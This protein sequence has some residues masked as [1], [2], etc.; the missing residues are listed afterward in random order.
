MLGTRGRRIVATAAVLEAGIAGWVAGQGAV[1]LLAA[2]GLVTL[3]DTVWGVARR[4]SLADLAG[5]EVAMT[6]GI[7]VAFRDDPSLGW[8]LALA[9]V[10][11]LVRPDRRPA[12]QATG[13][14]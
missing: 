1:W 8:L 6:L 12:V 2:I 9:C 5:A 14:A 4:G 11:W 13:A 3:A 7:L 10:A